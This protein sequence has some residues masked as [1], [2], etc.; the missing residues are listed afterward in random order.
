M[1]TIVAVGTM[2]TALV[3]RPNSDF[4]LIEREVPDPGPRQ[5]RIKV[6]ACG[7]CHS[8]V[9]TKEGIW[10]G[11]QY[12]RSPGHEIAGVIDEVS[13]FYAQHSGLIKTL[14]GAAIA[15]ALAKMKEN[16]TRG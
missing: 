1:A 4:Q 11:I 9:L 8:D 3:S 12:P 6:E 15:I 16:A 7:V 5:V 2:K 14:G 13:R 10:P